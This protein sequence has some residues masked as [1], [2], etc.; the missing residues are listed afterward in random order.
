[1]RTR[2]Y[3]MTWL[4]KQGRWRKKFRKKQFSV[5]ARR[6]RALFPDLVKRTTK[7]GSAEAANVWWRAK[8]AKLLAASGESPRRSARAEPYRDHCVA[9]VLT[10]GLLA[11]KYLAH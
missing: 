3:E 4:K 2:K 8:E 11:E 6:L 1:M 7:T 5:S 10:V 9:D